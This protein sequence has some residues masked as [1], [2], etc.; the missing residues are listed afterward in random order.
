MQDKEVGLL[1]Q[2]PSWGLSNQLQCHFS[3]EILNSKAQSPKI[4]ALWV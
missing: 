4:V 1:I 3:V 2:K